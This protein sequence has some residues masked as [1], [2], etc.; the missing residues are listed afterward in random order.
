MIVVQRELKIVMN[1][2]RIELRKIRNKRFR[3][4]AP[5]DDNFGFFERNVNRLLIERIEPFNVAS[6]AV[7]S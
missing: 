6:A 1:T 5:K 3:I 4:L 2:G 7:K